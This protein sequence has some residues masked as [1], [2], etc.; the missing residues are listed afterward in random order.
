[1]AAGRTKKGL[2]EL[3]ACAL[4]PEVLSDGPSA[5]ARTDAIYTAKIKIA[6]H[7]PGCA[8]Q[9]PDAS[10]SRTYLSNSG[11]KAMNVR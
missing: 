2:R 7:I 4:F 10:C 1:M 8:S 9:A 3:G 5:F 6:F 11:R